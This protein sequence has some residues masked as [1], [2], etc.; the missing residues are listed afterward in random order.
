MSVIIGGLM[1]V[2]IGITLFAL[3]SANTVQK[4]QSRI[5]HYKK[6]YHDEQEKVTQRDILIKDYQEE[7]YI[8][9]LCAKEDK[10]KMLDLENNIELLANNMPQIK[11]LVDEDQLNN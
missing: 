4:Y 5:N 3:V 6:K 8:L 9:L 7:N 11:E 10:E 1:G 2:F